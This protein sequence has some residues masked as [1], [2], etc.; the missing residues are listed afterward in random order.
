MN[1]LALHIRDVTNITETNNDRTIT[2]TNTNT[3]KLNHL[4]NELLL[5]IC[6]Q[7][8][9]PPHLVC[10]R[11]TLASDGDSHSYSHLS[12]PILTSDHAHNAPIMRVN[13][14]AWDVFTGEQKLCFHGLLTHAAF[15]N[16]GRDV[17]YFANL[18]T[19]QAFVGTKDALKEC[20]KGGVKRLA[21]DGFSASLIVKDPS[22]ELRR[23]AS[24]LT[25]ACRLFGYLLYSL[26]RLRKS[27]FLDF[28]G[29]SAAESARSCALARR[30]KSWDQGAIHACTGI[31]DLV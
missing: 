7:Y 12:S 9:L 23:P 19:P 14:C 1:N 27:N 31:L 21:V 26:P 13:K 4:P 29:G 17:L 24:V 30:V 25:H 10:I 2:T 6:E 20:R 3:K 28:S 16:D 5:K 18:A 8:V 11:Y 15:F 22:D